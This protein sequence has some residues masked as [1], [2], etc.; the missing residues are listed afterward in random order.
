MYNIAES[1]E[2]S[3]DYLSWPEEILRLC[4]L[5]HAPLKFAFADN[6]KIV[7][8]L[9]GI[10]HQVM[11]LY[12]CSNPKCANFHRYFNPAPRYDFNTS[13]FGK[14]VIAR[15]AKELLIFKQSPQ[16]IQFR[17]EIDY[18]MQI[19]LRTVQR[20]CRDILLVKSNQIDET[21]KQKIAKNKGIIIAADAQNPGQKFDAIWLFTDAYSGRLLK[22]VMASSMTSSQLHDQIEM[23]VDQYNTRLLGAVSDK[24]NC[25]K[26]CFEEFYPQI[27]HQYCTY[28]FMDH[29]WKHLELFDGKIF[30]KLNNFVKSLYINTKSTSNPV[31]F[32]GIGEQSVQDIFAPINQDFS[33]MC[34]VRNKKF[35]ELRGLI[36]FRNLKRYAGKIEQHLEN[37]IPTQR[38]EK[39]LF[40]L[41][42]RLQMELSDLDS[43]FREALFMFDMFQLIY[44]LIY[45]PTLL[46]MEKQESLDHIFGQIWAI[47]R[48][49]DPQLQLEQIRSFLPKASSNCAEILGEWVRLW[50]SYLPGLFSYYDF[51]KVIPT[52]QAQEQA[53]SKE[54]MALIRR[55]A[56]KEVGQMLA[57]QG[58]KYLRLFHCDPHEMSSDI[59]DAF[60]NTEIRL[61]RQEYHEQTA[62]IIAEWVYKDQQFHGID[63]VI[64]LCKKTKK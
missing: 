7:R 34:R 36:I 63:D 55:M 49:K 31:L 44:H 39:I 30:Q 18:E 23:I 16:Q 24:Q 53:F 48:S 28:H 17:L 22:T 8:N 60:M 37:R 9:D 25:L 56:K 1:E 26:K 52:N 64:K 3:T 14:D 21:T 10:V 58:E 57:F 41:L 47:A 11:Y 33:K 40:R 43:E 12:T 38:I 42:P 61:V 4:D 54:K 50:N 46:R 45:A 13:Y 20:M 32:E 5:C 2:Y 29:L 15:V 35:E 19:D 51:P 6:G 59:V 62:K 27:P